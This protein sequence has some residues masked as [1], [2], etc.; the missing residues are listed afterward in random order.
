MACIAALLLM[1]ALLCAGVQAAMAA[2]QTLTMSVGKIGE[3]A[4]DPT[5]SSNLKPG[6]GGSREYHYYTHWEPLITL[7]RSGNIIPWMAESYEVSDDYK[8]MTFHLRKGITFADGT[9]LNASVLKYNFDRIITYGLVDF[10]GD[11]GQ[12]WLTFVNYDHSEASD[13]Y[14]FKMYF[15]RGWL[16]IARD[17]A[18][19]VVFGQ[20]ISPTDVDPVWDIKG[21]LKPDKRYNGL[22]PY[23]VD[24]NESISKQ[25]TV[26]IRRHNWRDDC[27]F[28]KPMLDKIILTYIADPK[29]AIMALEKG[30]IDY[31]CRYF[32]PT[33][34]ALHAL[35][36]NPKI[37]IKT[38]PESYMYYLRTA[39]WRPPFNGTDGISLRK[40]ICY[41]FNRT[42]M[43]GGVFNG[44][45]RPAT[46]SMYLA[47]NRTDVPKCC[48]KGYDYDSDKARKLLT[49][50]GWTDTDG[51]GIV[52]KNGKALRELNLVIRTD[53]EIYGWQ[54]GMALIV[55]SQLK[56]IGIA[57]KI[58]TV[59]YGT[60]SKLLK[61]GDFDLMLSNNIGNLYTPAMD[62][63]NFILRKSRGTTDH[64]SNLN[65]T[66][67]TIV[68]KAQSATSKE[69]RDDCLCQVCNMLY[70]D[71][72]VIPLVYQVQYAVMSS[73]VKG[74]QFGISMN[75]YNMDHVEECWIES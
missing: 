41:A 70:E 72:G 8:I 48:G 50:A 55:Q 33:T 22:G 74:F 21:T 39:Y 38:T 29:T 28:H 4:T 42:E 71:A 9:P 7:D 17:F 69:E 19:G 65:A 26:L 15:T 73:K 31:I 14:T 46:D 25:K 1:S 75:A 47:P 16:N 53:Q 20:F 23:Y 52:D 5:I 54:K 34:D 18:V 13:E 2:E 57:I 3:T 67:E 27:N 43:V 64:Y 30:E 68:E 59:D 35:E 32:N 12:N 63:S 37:S 40:V 62:L 44:Y 45:A 51:D 6:L 61:S 56:R 60:Y 24:E 66:L 49:D 10:F 36:K 58:Q 11:K